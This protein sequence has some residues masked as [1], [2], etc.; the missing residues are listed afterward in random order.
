MSYLG[1]TVSRLHL[2]TSKRTTPA[3]AAGTPSLRRASKP[4][5]SKRNTRTRS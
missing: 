2:T 5:T 3:I 1:W 4:A